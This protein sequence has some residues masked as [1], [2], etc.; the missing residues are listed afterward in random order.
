MDPGGAVVLV[1]GAGSGIGRATAYLLAARGAH[2]VAVGRDAAAL[3]DV[4]EATGGTAVQ[5]DL[6]DPAEAERSVRAAREARGRLDG[7]VANAGIG[8]AGPVADMTAEQVAR[9]VDVNVRG[10]LLLG[11]AAAAAFGEQAAA[12]DHRARGLV[13]VTSIAGAVGVPGE[14]V[15]SATKAA[16]ESFAVVLREE[17]RPGGVTVATVL[18]GVVDTPFFDRRGVPYD[19]TFPRPVPPERVARA[20]VAALES[21]R[22]RTVV[23]RWLAVPAWLS[24]AVPGPYRALARRFS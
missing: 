11:R 4:A 5:A 7:V 13:F 12:G 1:T 9:L 15:Y 10:T 20:V 14:S 16:V 3:R 17:L 22:A 2:V 6:R 21:G 23:P 8:H 19:R 24:A 18:P